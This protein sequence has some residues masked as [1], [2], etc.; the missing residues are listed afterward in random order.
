MI[1]LNVQFYLGILIGGLA[2]VGYFTFTGSTLNW[3]KG[4]K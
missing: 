4:K 2:A 1:L 3:K